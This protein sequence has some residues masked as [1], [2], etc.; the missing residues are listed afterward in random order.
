[1]IDASMF[2]AVGAETCPEPKSYASTD[3]GEPKQAFSDTA[4]LAKIRE[5]LKADEMPSPEVAAEGET[6]GETVYREGQAP[7]AEEPVGGSTASETP[8]DEQSADA[9]EQSTPA[10]GI[11][12]AEPLIAQIP[13]SQVAPVQVAQADPNAEGVVSAE[14]GAAL[15]PVAS[16][17]QVVAQESLSELQ[18]L[19]KEAVTPEGQEGEQAAATAAPVQS[20]VS[21]EA[22][23]LTDASQTEGL[24]QGKTADSAAVAAQ[25]RSDEIVDDSRPQ[26]SQG[27]TLDGQ[28]N[29]VESSV[30]ESSK[31]EDVAGGLEQ[32]V[33]K[34]P[35][36]AAE[37]AVS[38][39]VEALRPEVDAPVQIA[40]NKTEGQSTESQAAQ[41]TAPEINTDAAGQ[42][43]MQE[44]GTGQQSK[45][46][47]S[48]ETGSG[49]KS[50]VDALSMLEGGSSSTTQGTAARSTDTPAIASDAQAVKS[51]V[52]EVGEQILGSVQA[53]LARGDKQIMIRLDPPELGSVVVRFEE[54]GDQVSGVLEVNQDE[55]R[56]DVEQAL[57]QVLR[58]LQEAGVQVRRLEV[59]DPA[60]R[61]PGREH[62]QQE[63]W[64]QR[65]GSDQQGEH[66]HRSPQ[67]G[68]WSALR[69][70]PQG[71]FEQAEAGGAAQGAGQ[72][73]I[74][75]LI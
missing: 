12:T 73:R 35:A 22:Q 74:D 72:G 33:A 26:T 34:A 53:S 51:P 75:M 10:R 46:G 1:M 6:G 23:V 41:K 28:T 2:A 47:Q 4:P 67:G 62:M 71:F 24:P 3:A 54:R 32:A 17:T 38:E 31:T 20:T 42:D 37:T 70:S 49:G 56:R 19:A 60:T 58:S 63:A 57:P 65:D 13:G 8:S 15:Q 59:A 18:S 68:G 21:T 43:Q 50:Q 27:S 52:Q 5:E 66:P 61:D 48:A 7:A 30:V 64:T 39:E 25:V 45:E 44:M 16:G 69:G 40:Q 11:S 55:T 29:V 14:S 9:P 36:Q